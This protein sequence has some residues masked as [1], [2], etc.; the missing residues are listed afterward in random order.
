MCLLMLIH[1]IRDRIRSWQTSKANFQVRTPS[2]HSSRQFQ[3]GSLFDGSLG[4]EQGKK[5]TIHSPLTQFTRVSENQILFCLVSKHPRAILNFCVWACG[6]CT[7]ARVLNVLLCICDASSCILYCHS[8][9]HWWLPIKTH[10]LRLHTALKF[11]EM[12]YWCFFSHEL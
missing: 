11:A 7:M 4:W 6:L 10:H 2:W 12:R 1:G 3:A 8:P 9:G 5:H